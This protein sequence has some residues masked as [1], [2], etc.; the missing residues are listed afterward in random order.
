M[1]ANDN[2]WSS[3]KQKHVILCYL[4]SPE[5]LQ[6]TDVSTRWPHYTY[7]RGRSRI[8]TGGGA[9]PQAVG[10]HKQLC[11][12]F[13]KNCIKSRT[14]WAVVGVCTVPIRPPNAFH[15][16]LPPSLSLI[17]CVHWNTIIGANE[18]QTQTKFG[19]IV[20]WD[21]G[22]F[23]E[24]GTPWIRSACSFS[25]N[26]SWMGRV[27]FSSVSRTASLW[28]CRWHSAFALDQLILEKFKLKRTNN[29]FGSPTK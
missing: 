26:Y 19:I 18:Q 5:R 22:G 23:P 15:D 24:T 10:T 25:I 4:W 29:S 17:K 20:Y 3:N 21:F 2:N 12:I 27:R 28:P 13:L 11:Q 9:I 7:F 6:R 14:F 16:K 1:I 8:S